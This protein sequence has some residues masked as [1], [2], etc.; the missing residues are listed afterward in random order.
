MAKVMI[1]IPDEDLARI[2]DEAARRGTSRSALLRDAALN[3]LER[4]RPM[5]A[6]DALQRGQALLA[7]TERVDTT[8]W[9]RHDRDARDMGRLRRERS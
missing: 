4:P 7:G 9:I 8:S 1:S 2:D 6:R 5:C 3:E